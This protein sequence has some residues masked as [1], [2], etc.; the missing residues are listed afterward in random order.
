[1]KTKVPP[2]WLLQGGRGSE[3][4]A[5]KGTPPYG[6]WLSARLSTPGCSSLVGRMVLSYN[7]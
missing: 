7:Y 1:M 6:A 5:E 2:L 3:C 4:K